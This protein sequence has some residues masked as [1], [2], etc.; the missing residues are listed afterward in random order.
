MS[1]FYMHRGRVLNTWPII[2]DEESGASPTR[3][4]GGVGLAGQAQANPFS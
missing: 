2:Y 1:T 4:T 3:Y